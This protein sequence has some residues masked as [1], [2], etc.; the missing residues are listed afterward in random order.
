M[1]DSLAP[2]LLFVY[3][4]LDTLKQTIESLQQNVLQSE[5]DL[6]IFSD[7]AKT[8]KES[9]YVDE[10]RAYLK[11]I[12]GFKSIYIFEA[13]KN[14]GLANSIIDGVTQVINKYGKVIVLEDDLLTSPNFLLYMNQALNFY[15]KNFQIFSISGYSYNV[16]LLRK[17]WQ[18]D[19]YVTY[20]T[21]SWG[22]GCWKDR[23][24]L[25]EW[26]IKGFEKLI[27]DRKQMKRFLLLG[28]DIYRLLKKQIVGKIDSWAIRMCFSQFKQ[29]KF[30]I[31][32]KASKIQNIG[33]MP[34]ATHT[35]RGKRFRTILDS[36]N[37]KDFSFDQDVA[38]ND[39][40][41]RQIDSLRSIIRRIID[42]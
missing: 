24:A 15:E 12:S 29:N 25:V 13:G 27:D 2:I 32:P 18:K 23:W 33:F 16:P 41:L 3:K 38:V 17:N 6:F 19:Y 5:S 14:K 20:R 7:A 9:P 37:Q 35:A 8:N 10:V 42:R 21:S 31:Y 26:D 39:K 28:S 22:W 36:S 40:L 34:G 1:P 11:T 4:R 30:T